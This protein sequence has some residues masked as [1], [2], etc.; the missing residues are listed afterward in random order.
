[1]NRKNFISR[2]LAVSGLSAIPAQWVK[3][4]TKIYLLQC[5]IAGFQYYKG[6]SLLGSMKEGD[7]LELVREPANK[8]DDCAI[9]LHF[10]NQKIGF[11]P[12]AENETL[13]RLLDAGVVEL[14]AEITHVKKG[15][16]AWENVCIA[17]YVLK[18][19]N[20]PLPEHAGYLTELDTP[21]Y[22]SLKHKDGRVS[23]V[24]KRDEDWYGQILEQCN[25]SDGM[26]YG[27]VCPIMTRQEIWRLHQG[28]FVAVHKD[29][30]SKTNGGKKLIDS[31]GQAASD[32]DAVFDKDGYIVLQTEKLSDFL[33]EGYE[34]GLIK[35]KLGRNFL[36]L[37][38]HF[39]Y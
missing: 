29:E 25:G 12:A 31:L 15:A 22:H 27:L 34:F 19:S 10:N 14:M 35:D 16:A 17:V 28:D 1:M 4:Y 21:H 32:I 6:P 18:E 39:S 8:Y 24:E 30:M 33:K 26:A 11:I 9:A 2:V 13:S 5:F 3:S 23:R 37:K 7:M 20:E 38:F 36:E